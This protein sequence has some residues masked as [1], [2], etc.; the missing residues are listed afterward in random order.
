MNNFKILKTAALTTMFLAFCGTA[1]ADRN[2]NEVLINSPVQAVYDYV[3]QPD[4]W[5][6]WHPVSLGAQRTSD[7]PLKVGDTFTEQIRLYGQENQMNYRVDI[8]SPPHE[9]KTSFTSPMIDGSIHY[10]LEQRGDST[11]FHR[12]LDYSID[13]YVVILKEGMQEVSGVA[14]GNLQDKLENE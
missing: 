8:A 1:Q 14:L 13:K 6:E 2:S 4:R 10:K 7:E 5:H 11:L 3:S 12:T 9:F